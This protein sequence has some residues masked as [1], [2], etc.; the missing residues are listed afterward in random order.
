[1]RKIDGAGSL[2][3]ELGTA[4]AV[5]AVW[6][7]AIFAPMHQSSGLAR[8]L[9][10]R[11]YEPAALWTLCEPGGPQT[12]DPASAV[13]FCP[14]HWVGKEDLFTPTPETEFAPRRAVFALSWTAL[15]EAPRETSPPEG[16][17]QPRAPPAFS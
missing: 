6:L 2:S 12:G 10:A 7:L 14:A 16:L 11:G 9:A 5:L 17:A 1:M 8:D 4:L 13:A 15:R 3:R